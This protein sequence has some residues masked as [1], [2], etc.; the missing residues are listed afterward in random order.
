MNTTTQKVFGV[1]VV[2]AALLGALAF[3]MILFGGAGHP[4]G[5]AASPQG[6]VY[7][8]LVW[9]PLGLNVGSQQQLSISATGQLTLGASGTAIT[10]LA[11]GT[12]TASTTGAFA[13]TTSQAFSC[14]VSNAVAGENVD[15][16]LPNNQGLGAHGGG[17]V[18]LGTTVTA[19][20]V[21]WTEENLTGASTSSFPLATTSV[22]Y[23]L[24]Q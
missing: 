7:P 21:Q 3:S 23:T 13:A 19:G 10:N 20:L 8:N 15:I 11:N 18:V 16:N 9:Y 12:C 2:V 17:F 22:G 14:S 4:A 5:L 1:V 6:D 24:T